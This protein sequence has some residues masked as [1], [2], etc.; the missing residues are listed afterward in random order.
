MYFLAHRTEKYEI[1]L[2]SL[3]SITDTST[4]NHQGGTHLL[5]T[6]HEASVDGAAISSFDVQLAVQPAEQ[7]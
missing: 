1:W 4:P 5:Y 3:P 6:H 7:R 2:H